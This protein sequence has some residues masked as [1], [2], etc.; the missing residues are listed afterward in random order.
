M[1]SSNQ[2]QNNLHRN[3]NA[4]VGYGQSRK[5]AI[6][7][8]LSELP[9]V[10]ERVVYNYTIRKSEGESFGISI[11]GGLGTLLRGIY[12]KSVTPHGACGKDGSI[13]VGDQIISLNGHCLRETT[14]EHAVSCFRQAKTQIEVV[15]S[16]MVESKLQKD[17]QGLSP[18]QGRL[19]TVHPDRWSEEPIVLEH[20]CIHG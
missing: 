2:F 16:R 13:K 14:H 15:I 10:P 5:L 17:E 8:V 9:N 11:V 19:F 7:K 12:V 1:S 4:Y 3:V 6:K 18:Y 20:K